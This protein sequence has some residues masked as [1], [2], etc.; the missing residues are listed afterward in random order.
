[1][2][3]LLASCS[4]LVGGA[5]RS[6]LELAVGLQREGVELLVATGERAPLADL[7]AAHR[8]PTVGLAMVPLARPR[9]P[10]GAL[11]ATGRI[12]ASLPR[13]AGLLRRER[14]SVLHC[15]DSITQAWLGPAALLAGVPCL[16]HC[17]DFHPGRHVHR[18]LA[19]CAS[20][21]ISVSVAVDAHLRTLVGDLRPRHVVMGGIPGPASLPD[22]GPTLPRPLPRPSPVEVVRR[23]GARVV[24]A[25]AGQL[26]PRKG[27]EVLLPAFA[28]AHA[29]R[30]DIGLALAGL[31][32]GAGSVPYLRRLRREWRGL[33]CRR[34]IACA[35]NRIHDVPAWFGQADLVAVPS[36]REPFGRVAVEAMAARRPVIV[37]DVD[38]LRE[39]VRHDVDGLRVAPADVRG[40]TA[41]LLDL[42]ADPAKREAMAA[43]GHERASACFSTDRVVREVQDLYRTYAKPS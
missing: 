22:P 17:R 10:L 29:V 34:A 41:A 11:A 24:I 38:G 33:A 9:T 36:R 2:R 14:I 19:R 21:C 26:I 31:S 30:P 40:W 23:R 39:I 16:W 25:W 4:R 20:G 28:A 5:E 37:A 42:A 32:T 12:V 35:V 13:A 18:C 15:N 1:M 3:V 6:L 8:V 43:R 27:L 7:L